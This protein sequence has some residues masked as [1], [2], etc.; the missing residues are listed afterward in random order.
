M[1]DIKNMLTMGWPE[2]IPLSCW[3]AKSPK[4]LVFETETNLAIRLAVHSRSHE[5]VGRFINHKGLKIIS[6]MVKYV[7]SASCLDF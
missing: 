5:Q 3:T 1:Q 6:N 2:Q 4:S 7:S